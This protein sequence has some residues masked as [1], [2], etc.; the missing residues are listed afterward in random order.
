MRKQPQLTPISVAFVHEHHVRHESARC[1]RDDDLRHLD[2][3]PGSGQVLGDVLEKPCAVGGQLRLHP[4]GLFELVQARALERLAARFRGHRCEG[5][6][7]LVYGVWMGEGKP[8]RTHDLAR[9]LER[10]GERGGRVAD[11]AGPVGVDALELASGVRVGRL[12]RPCC[13]RDRRAGRE[14]QAQPRLERGTCSGARVD[15]HELAVVDQPE[16]AP[17]RAQEIGH[18]RHERLCHLRR[19]R[20]GRERAREL[21]E[22]LRRCR[23]LLGLGG[24]RRLLVAKPL[25]R[26]RDP[27][28]DEGDDE[29]DR[30]ASRDRA[31]L[32]RQLPARLFVEEQAEPRGRDGD[33]GREEAE[34]DGD[35][36]DRAHE[37]CHEHLAR[38]QLRSQHA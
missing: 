9:D 19:R 16:R 15:D 10:H 37:R 27:D 8:R 38:E 25:E 21:L 33:V 1:L 26:P 18:V 22:V 36:H 6:H 3:C 29:A 34:K 14:R 24:S 35:E 32:D 30:P 13:G 11:E 28:E 2:G 17:G 7:F 23:R 31:V 4:L 20:C 5:D 12:P